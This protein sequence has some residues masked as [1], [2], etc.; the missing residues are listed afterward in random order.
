M[1]WGNYT[2]LF[3]SLATICASVLERVELLYVRMLM[4]SM[5]CWLQLLCFLWFEWINKAVQWKWQIGT[6]AFGISKTSL[7]QS[8]R[9]CWLTCSIHF[10]RAP[11][12]TLTTNYTQYVCEDSQSSKSRLP[13]G[14]LKKQFHQTETWKCHCQSACKQT[15]A[16]EPLTM[17]NMGTQLQEITWLTLIFGC[18]CK[19]CIKHS[20]KVLTT[21][22]CQCYIVNDYTLL[23]YHTLFLFLLLKY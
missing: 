23:Y 4:C 20:I 22:V 5:F 1:E 11:F 10:I 14:S 12:R 2:N 17:C 13:R 21:E 8:D 9:Q 7:P 3:L 16:F 18:M 15:S 19:N 6:Q